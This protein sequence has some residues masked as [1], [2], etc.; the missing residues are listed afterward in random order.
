MSRAEEFLSPSIVRRL[1]AAALLGGLGVLCLL[2]LR[3][4]VVPVVWAV[5]LAYVSWPVYRRVR[6][7]CGGRATLAATAMTLL[8]ALLLILPTVALVVVVQREIGAALEATQGLQAG[9]VTLPAP[10][11]AIPWLG[12]AAQ[13]L[14]DRYA[15]DPAPLRQL[16][17]D[18]SRYFRT[19]LYGAALGVLHNA[20]KLL[21]ALVTAF[22]LYRDGA[23]L[24]RQVEGLLRRA[25]GE[26]LDRYLQAAG[27]MVRAVVYGLLISSLA[28][29]LLAT[30]GYM[31][32][33]AAAPALLGA[34]TALAAI[35]P[36]VGTFLVWGPVAATLI[37]SGH[38]IQGCVLLG[39][40]TLI[41]HPV[42][43]IIKPLLISN[44]TE[45]PILLV[46]FGVVGGLAAFGLVGVFVGPVCLAVATAM[47]R[48]WAD[49]TR[50][51]R[52][53]AS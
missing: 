20:F 34:L 39:W 16:L 32:V 5:I 50:P 24:R 8:V 51:D 22:F 12:G 23:T 42:D 28:Q 18:A 41:V 1:L 7:G 40:G 29:G 31:M 15:A 46:L 37:L 38:T 4:F 35:V 47:W 43:N 13:Q 19:D 3:P 44:A 17:D 52:D 53:A 36:V 10:V 11:R 27:S 14:L 48:E 45:M 49:E 9:G 30:L 21:L 25:F 26:R 6:L 2:V 33:G